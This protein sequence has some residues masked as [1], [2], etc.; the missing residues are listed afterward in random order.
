MLDRNLP[1]ALCGGNDKPRQLSHIIPAF[2]FKHTSVRSPTGYIRN[3]LM[4]NRRMQ[5]GPKDY[6]LCASCEQ[7]FSDWERPF[8]VTY[9]RYYEDRSR[10]IIYSKEDALCALS[11]V[12]RVLYNARSHPELIHLT[13]GSDYSRTD[14]AFSTWSGALLARAN[15][16]RFR[17]Y[18]LFFDTIAGGNNLPAGI[19]SYIFH[20]SDFDLMAGSKGSFAYVHLPGLMIFGMTEDH[21]KS[22]W[23]DL[24]V[25][26]NGGVY[27][28]RNRNIPGH[29]GMLI[30]SRI[31]LADAAKGAISSK[32]QA[33]ILSDALKDPQVLYNSPI[34][35]AKM[36]DLNLK[37]DS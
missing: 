24:R 19:N 14:A 37:E 18:W 33:K 16:G 3:S 23:R 22:E 8:S 28:H 9:K 36:A 32:Q 10:A 35:A 15:P 5:D 17:L 2:I 1:C 26:F 34:A 29:I 4:P 13:L 25:S 11:L 31:A 6:I 27:T 21:N 7:T 12:W 30:R 20:G